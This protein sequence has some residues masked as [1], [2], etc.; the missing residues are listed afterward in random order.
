MRPDNLQLA[1]Q[2]HTDEKSYKCIRLFKQVIRGGI[3]QL[4]L[5][6]AET[7]QKGADKKIIHN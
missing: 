6:K 2:P 4:T 7:G 1:C 5:E 3:G